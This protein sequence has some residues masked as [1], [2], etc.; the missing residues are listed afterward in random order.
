MFQSDR[1]RAQALMVVG[2]L[3]CLAAAC[4]GDKNPSGEGAAQSSAVTSKGAG[5][6]GGRPA[7]EQEQV[8]TADEVTSS[9]QAGA[10]G[11][12]QA[13]SGNAAGHA[14]SASGAGKGGAGAGA[15]ASA[16]PKPSAAAGAGGKPDGAGGAGGAAGSTS[17]SSAPAGD[18]ALVA[19]TGNKCDASTAASGEMCAGWL[20]GVNADTLKRAVDPAG[21]CSSSAEQICTGSLVMAVASCAA[22]NKLSM[23]TASNDELRAPVRDCV[24]ADAKIKET[25]HVECI[26]CILDGAVCASD[27]CLTQCLGGSV[28]ECNKCRLNAKCDQMLY[29]CGGLPWPRD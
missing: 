24:L 10:G 19:G 25:T 28:A 29:A 17:A 9:A 6:S 11:K 1:S 7:D 23:P 12:A 20:C 8:V 4:G 21:A 2:L 5:G 18:P 22:S 27:H 16:A 26:D 14:G 13:A 15:V 3:S